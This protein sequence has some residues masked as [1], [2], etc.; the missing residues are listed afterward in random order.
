MGSARN[1]QK[2]WWTARFA[3]QMAAARSARVASSLSMASASSAQLWPQT[4]PAAVPRVCV[5]SASLPT[6][7]FLTDAFLAPVFTPTARRAP[8]RVS[9]SLAQLLTLWLTVSVCCVISMCL[10]ANSALQVARALPV[11]LPTSPLWASATSA[12]SSS[13]T[14]PP[15]PPMASAQPVPLRMLCC[16]VVVLSVRIW[17][18]TVKLAMEIPAQTAKMA[19]TCMKTGATTAASS[20]PTAWPVPPLN[21]AHSA[22]TAIYPF[23]APASIASLL[24]PTVKS[25]RSKMG[26]SSV[27]NAATTSTTSQEAVNHAQKCSP[28]VPDAMFMVAAKSAT[29]I[30]FCKALLASAAMRSFRIASSATN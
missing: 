9:A 11:P 15:A 18:K 24:C 21:S 4:V 16:R 12:V 23:W 10:I 7:I 22:S 1:A 13:L 3:I 30:L 8:S 17:H 19:T 25:V 6:P 26:R 14:A 28:G 20:F 29:Q 27:P 5:P 2:W